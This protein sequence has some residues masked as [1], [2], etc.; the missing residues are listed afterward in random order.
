VPT[1]VAFHPERQRG[2]FPTLPELLM[3]GAYI[4]LAFLCFGLAVKFFAVLPG[5][6]HGWKNKFRVIRLPQW[7]WTRHHDIRSES[8]PN[9]NPEGEPA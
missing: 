1:T 6:T 4:S 5:D 9:T 8:R 3:A 7:P 2:Y